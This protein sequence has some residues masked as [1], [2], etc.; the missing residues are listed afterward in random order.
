MLNRHPEYG[1]A[2]HGYDSG[3]MSSR[4]RVMQLMEW[5]V[6]DVFPYPPTHATSWMLPWAGPFRRLGRRGAIARTTRSNADGRVGSCP[7]RQSKHAGFRSCVATSSRHGGSRV[8]TSWE[9]AKGGPDTP[10]PVSLV[11][12][13][14]CDDRG[15]GHVTHNQSRDGLRRVLFTRVI[16]NDPYHQAH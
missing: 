2:L 16:N 12:S 6:G 14:V 5:F 1:F 10:V 13:C 7:A 15:I 9:A 8:A 3:S 4:L 11:A